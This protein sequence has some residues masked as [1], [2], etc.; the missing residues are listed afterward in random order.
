MGR[1]RVRG[2]ERRRLQRRAAPRAL[3]ARPP[4]G[5]V[6]VQASVGEAGRARALRGGRL[7]HAVASIATRR[8]HGPA[9]V[10]TQAGRRAVGARVRGGRAQRQ[11]ESRGK[12]LR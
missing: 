6:S 5:L 2:G 10:R 1:R 8:G 11:S 12:T 9:P 7:R 3:P 4:R